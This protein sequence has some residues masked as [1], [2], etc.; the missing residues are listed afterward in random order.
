MSRLIQEKLK[1]ALAS[2]LLFGELCNGGVAKVGVKKDQLV[3]TYENKKE[4]ITEK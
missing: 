4:L 1:K 3:I 2:E